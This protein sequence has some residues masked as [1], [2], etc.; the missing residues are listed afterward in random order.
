MA[1][2]FTSLPKKNY[3]SFVAPAPSPSMSEEI[4]GPVAADDPAVQLVWQALKNIR[5][6]A[7]GAHRAALAIHQDDTMSETGRHLK[8][9]ETA[10]KV[11]KPA[12]PMVDR[13]REN[14]QT[15]MITKL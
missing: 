4:L 1:D 14:L 11:I 9:A 8:A 5:L 12:L 6:A 15:A 7:H 10:H 13:A 3:A 2:T